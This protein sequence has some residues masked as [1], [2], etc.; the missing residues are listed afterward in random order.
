[1]PFRRTH[2][3]KLS[4]VGVFAAICLLAWLMSPD[5]PSAD[6]PPWYGIVPPL[7]A[8]TLALL[9]NR[10][11]LSLAAAVVAGGFLAAAN[12]P[13]GPFFWLV[14]GAGRA[15]LFVCQTV[16]DPVDCT[17]NVDQ[18]GILVFVVLIMAM[19]SV[20]LVAGGLQGVA[21][22][23][24][25]F[26][27]TA[28]STQLATVALGLVIFIDDYANTMIVGTTM[29][30][31]TDRQRISREKLAFLVDATAAPIAGIAILSTW[32]GYEVGLL[33][34]TARSLGM[35]ETGYEIFFDAIGFRF[36]CILMIAFVVLNAWSGRDFGP[37]AAAQRRARTEGKP[38]PDG[39]KAMTSDAFAAAQPHAGARI[40][41]LVAVA[42]MLAVLLVF[43]GG[44]WL[45]GRPDADPRSVFRFSAWRE[46]LGKADSIL[47]LVYASSAGLLLAMAAA[48]CIA[49]VPFRP[50]AWAVV[51]GAKGSLLPVTVLVLAWSLKGTCEELQTGKFLAGAVE[52]TLQP[53]MLPVLIFFIAGLTS[54]ATGT[55]W[56]T[57]AVL[58]PT[59]VP[60]AFHL[61]G[62]VYGPLT[63]ISVA[64]ILDGAIFGD[65]CSPVS[66]TTIMSS[67]A[68]SC[69]HLAHVRTQIPYSLLV[70]GL[71]VVLGYLPAAFG[72]PSWCSI[73]A[74]CVLMGCLFLG[75]RLKLQ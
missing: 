28:R 29:R 63:V 55:S 58:I 74:G 1:M 44:L 8:V 45:T 39:A 73:A 66:D 50:I 35:D 51:N 13:A 42:P 26:A 49:R 67:T 31:V 72:L 54:F 75:L 61:D 21:R 46:A 33:S 9:T 19:I 7:L 12:D 18:I 37:M 69:D 6:A 15:E 38:L 27:R 34:D 32:I 41:A 20:V 52:G 25:K 70:A 24:E 30:P 16:F 40:R 64:A 11:R 59:A 17:F 14:V 22:W 48:R 47:L 56:G 23:L 71:A 10:M 57:M 65:H 36:Y 4:A 53:W 68:S 62:E 60:V 5:T 43:L 3:L 2:I